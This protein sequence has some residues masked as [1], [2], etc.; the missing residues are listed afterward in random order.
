MNNECN[1][2]NKFL[3][4]K[5]ETTTFVNCREKAG[6]DG[7]YRAYSPLKPGTEV[8]VIGIA[9]ADDDFEW[10]IVRY[11]GEKSYVSLNCLKKK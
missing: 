2:D 7:K 6:L 11:N 8:E 3:S 1:K 5:A 9:K 4:F 10:A